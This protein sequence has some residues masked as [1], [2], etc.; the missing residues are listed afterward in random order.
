MFVFCLQ[1][2]IQLLLAVILYMC[3]WGTSSSSFE[4]MDYFFFWRCILEAENTA[5]LGALD[6]LNSRENSLRNYINCFQ[7]ELSRPLL[8]IFQNKFS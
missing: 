7:S 8:P 6:I 3:S 5:A 4:T 2:G 1:R